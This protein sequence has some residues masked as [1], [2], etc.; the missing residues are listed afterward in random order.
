M[1]SIKY[2]ML[3]TLELLH[4]YYANRLC[5]DFVIMPSAKT[6]AVLQGYKM[7][8]KQYENSLYVGIATNDTG[9][10][11]IKPAEGTPLTFFLQ[12]TNPLFFNFTNLPFA[13]PSGKLYYFTNRVANS[14][15][16][17]QFL[18][19]PTPFI[20][21]QQY[22]PGDI[23]TNAGGTTFQAIRTSTGNVPAPG[24]FW[25]EVDNNHYFSEKDALQWLPSLSTY[26]FT[27][28]QSSAVIAVHGFNSAAPQD[29]DT[30]VYSETINFLKPVTAFTL[31]L[32]VLPPGKYKVSV[33]GDEQTAYINDELSVSKA[34]AI[35]DVY[36]ENTLPNG[37]KILNGNDLLSPPYSIFF[38]NR[39]TIWKYV[40][41]S[42]TA[43]VSDNASVYQ[44]SAPAPHTVAS[45]SP[46]PLQ[47][48]PLNL[49]LSVNAQDYT[50]IACAS[51]QRL[52]KQISGSDTYYCSEIFLNY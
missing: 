45:L 52:S 2:N 19:L 10:P 5:T 3:F 18:S 50:P 14:S 26:S 30:L 9:T 28:P 4:G 36:V 49:T 41:T 6:A 29:Y 42:A 24:N 33:N 47:E 13:Y 17:K 32:R 11:I 20:G 34:F 16:G 7:I 40:L 25:M 27:A 46:I 1:T 21:T 43:T 15:N 8:A 48:K 37:Y 44:F 23:A 51:P 35:V 39:A 31:D 12:L 38:L 22:L